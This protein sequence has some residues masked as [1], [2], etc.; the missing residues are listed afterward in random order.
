[1]NLH[2][3]SSLRK[4]FAANV[5]RQVFTIPERAS[6]NVRGKQGKDCLDSKR[7]EHIKQ[8]SFK[9]YPLESQE[10]EKSTWNACVVAIDEVNRRLNKKAKE[11]V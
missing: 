10:T 6:S 11:A 7:I 1:M 8:I 2:I 3:Y 5:N 9:M 4:N